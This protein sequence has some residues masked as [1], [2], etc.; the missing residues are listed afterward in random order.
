M[1]KVIDN[2]TADMMVNQGRI[3]LSLYNLVTALGNDKKK[4]DT[5]THVML[6]LAKE[7][8]NLYSTRLMAGK[9]DKYLEES[10]RF[11]YQWENLKDYIIRPEPKAIAEPV[12]K[13]SEIERLKRELSLK[14]T[15]MD[16]HYAKM[17]TMCDW[18]RK[19]LKDDE[20]LY[21]EFFQIVANGYTMDEQPIYHQ[22]INIMRHSVVQSTYDAMLF[23]KLVERWLMLYERLTSEGVRI[24]TIEEMNALTKVCQE[25]MNKFKVKG[26][27]CVLDEE[28]VQNME[29][30]IL[31]LHNKHN[32]KSGEEEKSDDAQL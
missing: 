25:N 7:T 2:E 18:A 4:W 13:D 31:A 30:F 32:V 19:N 6:E 24:S 16:S 8:L 12:D 27:N 26:T 28:D 1:D 20:K 15:T 14:E 17:Q 3:I 10:G 29:N 11:I 21:N 22:R 9:I 23:Y 5:E